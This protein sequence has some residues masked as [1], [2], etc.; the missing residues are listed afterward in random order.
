MG[1]FDKSAQNGSLDPVSGIRR[2]FHALRRVEFL[3]RLHQ[4]DVT[5]LD[6]IHQ[7]NRF[8]IEFEGNFHYEFEIG[9]Y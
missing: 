9:V 6:D 2:E 3:G 1:G 5:V 7:G 4:T 8:F